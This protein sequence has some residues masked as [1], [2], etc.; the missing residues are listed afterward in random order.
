MHMMVRD[1]RNVVHDH[2]PHRTLM[3]SLLKMIAGGGGETGSGGWTRESHGGL[4]TRT[5]PPART[6]EEQRAAERQ[7][8]LD[9]IEEYRAMERA[10]AARYRA[11]KLAT[12]L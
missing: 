8:R 4:F 10:R 5:R 7:H 1:G 2:G 3:P 6:E 11:R 9:N 12:A